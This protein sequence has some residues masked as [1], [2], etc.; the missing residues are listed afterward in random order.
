MRD[1]IQH[2]ATSYYSYG[3]V[4][5]KVLHKKIHTRIIDSSNQIM[6]STQL[7]VCCLHSIGSRITRDTL[8]TPI[9]CDMVSWAAQ[10]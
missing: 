5:V 2:H 3:L 8:H 1:S 4:W 7:I 9:G 6:V 10:S